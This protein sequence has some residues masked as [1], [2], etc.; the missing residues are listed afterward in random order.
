ML[1]ALAEHFERTVIRGSTA[2][3]HR[4]AKVIPASAIRRLQADAFRRVVRYAA[5]NQKFFSDKLRERG[6]DASRIKR[7]EDLGDI[8]TTPEDLIAR[9]PEDFLC[10]APRLVF[11]TT[12]TSGPPKRLYFTYDEL[13]RS[14][15]YEAAGLAEIGIEPDDRVV[16][17]FDPGYWISSWVT[18]LAC[19]QLGVFCSATGKPQPRE[20]YER[21][22]VYRYNVLIADPTWLVSL[23]EIAEKEGT[24][25]L[26]LIVAAGD[27]MTDTY[28][29]YVQDVW[30]A[31][32]VLGY[33]S[34]EAGGGMGMECGR[35]RGYHVDEFNFLFEI[36]DLDAEG[37]GELV[38]T[39]LTR[40]TEPLIR[41]RARDVTRFL[42]EPCGCGVPL[43]R[44]DAIKGRRDEMVVM[45]AG[46][47]HPAI[48]ER[49]LHDVPG[50]SEGW[51]VAVRQ[52]G[53]RDVIEFRLELV[54]GIDADHVK[55]HVA[56]NLAGRCPDIWA[57]HL[58][59]MFQV[60]FQFL[61]HGSLGRTRKPKRLVD[62]RKS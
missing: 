39:T 29:T 53:L 43:K 41:Y 40:R 56:R 52:E 47:M 5:G 3:L 16:C 4:W 10:R 11:E 46:N 44:L 18:F 17:T 50:I 28:R 45:G 51:Q 13:D 35:S 20:I 9:P 31:P 7:P 19:K 34:T 62:E 42:G 24:F 36:V 2:S 33:G 26:K 23:S 49:V 61:P 1:S 14:A 21:M 38:F 57:N 25:P 12:G 27:R 15:R 22:R 60:A 32:I 54:D 48:F 37:F 59:G 8:F 30:K 6:L 58:C 55:E